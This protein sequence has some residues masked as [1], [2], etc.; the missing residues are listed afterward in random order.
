[1]TVDASK[2]NN[3]N[4]ILA[5]LCLVALL[6]V[7]VMGRQQRRSYNTG[8]ELK[9]LHE[10]FRYML[11]LSFI[12]V[13]IFFL[14]YRDMKML[15]LVRSYDRS[16]PT[17][18]QVLSCEEIPGLLGQYETQVIY[19]AG[20]PRHL[21]LSHLRQRRYRTVVGGSLLQQDYCRR[22]KSNWKSEPGAMMDLYLI[23]DQPRSAANEELLSSVRE[24]ISRVRLG[25]ILVP[26]VLLAMLFFFL[27]FEAVQHGH[28]RNRWISWIVFCVCMSLVLFGTWVFCDAGYKQEAEHHFFSA[29][30]VQRR[31]V[32]SAGETTAQPLSK[33]VPPAPSTPVAAITPVAISGPPTPSDQALEISTQ[34]AG[35]REP[36]GSRLRFADV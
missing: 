2:V 17:K 22:F 14:A 6:P 28:P 20:I 4:R 12:I 21:R 33:T 10:L 35:P 24:D 8:M 15:N 31:N 29:Y 19:S 32:L 34:G 1:M 11:G 30:A 9:D 36:E 3:N 23:P 5:V 26:G 7:E 27:C 16:N 18:G 25:M 13:G